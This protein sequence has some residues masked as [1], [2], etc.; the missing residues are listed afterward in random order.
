MVIEGFLL[1][2]EVKRE[3]VLVR[4]KFVRLQK[5]ENITEMEKRTETCW[6][7]TVSYTVRLVKLV[8]S[9]NVRLY[10]YV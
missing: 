3:S 1:M 2:R 4:T 9:H 6:K 7:L 5:G 8:E 10:M